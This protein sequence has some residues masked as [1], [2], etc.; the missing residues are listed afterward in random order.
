[1]QETLRIHPPSTEFPRIVCNDDVI[2]LSKPVIGVS[3]KVYNEFAIPKGTMAVIS[4]FGH[5]MWGIL[6][7]YHSPYSLTWC[8][9]IGTQRCGVPILMN[10]AQNDGSRQPGILNHQLEYTETCV[11]SLLDLWTSA[12]ALAVLPSPEASGLASDGD[13]RSCLLVHSPG[14]NLTFYNPLQRHRGALVLGYP[15]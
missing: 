2:P 1:M 10:G 6:R 9:P 11:S 12:D 3:G 14:G 4:P 8:N 15:H 13:S 5:N 7:I